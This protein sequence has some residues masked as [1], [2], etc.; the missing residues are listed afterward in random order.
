MWR[1][2]D[3]PTKSVEKG[4]EKGTCVCREKG[5]E[6]MKRR[7]LFKEHRGDFM[8]GEECVRGT[9]DHCSMGGVLQAVLFVKVVLFEPAVGDYVGNFVIFF[10]IVWP[11]RGKGYLLASS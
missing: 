3:I 6:D 8:S 7:I 9:G 11:W 2:I 10:K 4:E 5:N 1:G